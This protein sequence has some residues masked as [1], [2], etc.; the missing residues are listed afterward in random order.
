MWNTPEAF[1]FAIIMSAVAFAL[2][3]LYGLNSGFKTGFVCGANG[4]MSR[5]AEIGA[6]KTDVLDKLIAERNR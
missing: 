2:G 1:T 5:L 3:A 6:L 4:L